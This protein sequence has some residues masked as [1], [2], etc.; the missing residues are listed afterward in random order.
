MAV[1]VSNPPRFRWFVF[2]QAEDGIR[3]WSV[4]GVQTCALPIW[5]SPSPSRPNCFAIP[6]C[7]QGSSRPPIRSEERRV[8]EEC[9]SRWWP[10]HLKK[11]QKEIDVMYVSRVDG[12]IER[13]TCR[14]KC[15][16]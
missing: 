10:Y 9:R 4:T 15:A 14:D 5:P 13:H 1:S 2:S 6:R 8:G 7:G 11:K 12:R 3:D 16:L